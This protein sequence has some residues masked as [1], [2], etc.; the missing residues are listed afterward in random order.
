MA[1]MCTHWGRRPRRPML[2]R[3]GPL[4]QAWFEDCYVEGVVKQKGKGQHRYLVGWA[5]EGWKDEEVELAP[6]DHTTDEANPQ[7]WPPSLLG[8]CG[9]VA[10]PRMC[11]AAQVWH[12]ESGGLAVTRFVHW[13]VGLLAG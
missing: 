8:R 10:S 5:A 2:A 6:E 3:T 11:L 1:N 12:M 13:L 9:A 7:R 4:P